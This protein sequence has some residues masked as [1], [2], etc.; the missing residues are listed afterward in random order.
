MKGGPRQSWRLSGR[1]LKVCPTHTHTHTACQQNH[2][3]PRVKARQEVSAQLLLSSRVAGQALHRQQERTE[4]LQNPSQKC[5]KQTAATTNLGSTHAHAHAQERR[6]PAQ[7]KAS[8]EKLFR[9]M[10][11]GAQMTRQRVEIG[12][13]KCVQS[14]KEAVSEKLKHEMM[15]YQIETT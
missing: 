12:S 3:T 14:T 13:R 1:T 10:S 5:T 4:T 2:G 8:R 7:G 6:A 9:K 11:P 15:F